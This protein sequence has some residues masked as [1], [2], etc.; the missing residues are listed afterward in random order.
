MKPK[1]GYWTAVL[2]IAVIILISAIYIFPWSKS[3]S[4]IIFE[5]AYTRKVIQPKELSID[6]G[7][8]KLKSQAG[9]LWFELKENDT[10]HVDGPYYKPLEV[11]IADDLNKDTVTLKLF[12]DDYAMMLNYFSRS[13]HEDWDKRRRQLEEA[14]LDDAIILQ[15]HP[16]H[17]GI[18]ILN[19]QEFIDRLVLPVNSLKNLEIQDIVYKDHQI[20]NLRFVQKTTNTVSH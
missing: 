17:E 13:E 12:P 5:D 14:I 18:E 15:S 9:I 20:Y 6:F 19:K 2:I 8:N 16:Q 11:F 7:K 3:S 10:L 4:Y 1:I